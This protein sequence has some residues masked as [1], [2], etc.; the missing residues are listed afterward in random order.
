MRVVGQL[1]LV[2][3]FLAAGYGAY[4][5][6]A[7]SAFDRIDWQRNGRRLAIAAFALLT[8]VLGVLVHAL[9]VK[10]FRFE[11]VAHSTSTQLSWQY[12]LASLWVGQAGSI[13]LWAWI[14]AA[15]IVIF[16]AAMG[17]TRTNFPTEA[18]RE[19][20]AAGLPK[21]QAQAIRSTTLGLLLTCLTFLLVIL[22]TAA[23]PMKASAIQ[24]TEG[25]GLSPLLQHPAML[26][27]PPVVFAGYA[28][29]TV[30]FAALMAMLIHGS[31]DAQWL[32]RTSNWSLAAWATLGGGILL[33]AHWAYQELGWGGYWAWDPV[34]N[35]SLVPWLTGTALVHALMAWRYR[36]TLP[37]TAVALAVATFALCNWATFLTRSGIFSSVHAFS[38]S[39]IGWL[40]LGEMAVLASVG[41]VVGWRRRELLAAAQPFR[42]LWARETLILASVLLLTLFT[43]V[44]IVGTMIAPLSSMWWGRTVQFGPEF[45]NRVLAPVGLA[46]LA[47]TALV[48]L[49]RWG[50]KP[51]R[52]QIRMLGLAASCGLAFAIAAA[53]LGVRSITALGI[54]AIAAF[55][56]ATLVMASMWDSQRFGRRQFAAYVIHLGFTALSVGV[57]GSSLGTRQQQFEMGEGES[58]SWE[59]WTLRH[60]ELSQREEP[61]K[62]IAEARLEATGYGRQAALLVPARH[63]HKLQEE[64]TSEVAIH[65]SWRGDL[66]V[67]L[68]AGLGEGRILVTLVDNPLVAWLWWG[69]LLSLSGAAFALIFGRQSSLALTRANDLVEQPATDDRR[70]LA[71]AA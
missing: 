56:I 50:K 13:L 8:L 12:S 67:I 52:R 62:L 27:H 64:W 6:F 68:H 69:G 49:V 53:L 24:R 60:V 42:S 7:G 10:D 4:V 37:R 25:T 3:A 26:I 31:V 34:E 41:F 11:Y 1:A 46:L 55:A 32:K 2:A 39:P 57:A 47:L 29:W 44:V 22:V 40:F 15:I 51:N 58:I 63:L 65:S 35:G 48:P 28:L 33:G 54:T 45:Y 5:A 71:R 14:L 17:T 43:A 18:G 61:D 16:E 9:I 23:D 19:E 38:Q 20:Y 30:P 21:T 36:Q 70:R 66:Y 59:G